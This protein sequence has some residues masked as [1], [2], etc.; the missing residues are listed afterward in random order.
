MTKDLFWNKDI[1]KIPSIYHSI[2]TK[3]LLIMEYVEGINIDENEKLLKNGYD[4]LNISNL[5]IKI[6][7]YMIFEN[8]HVHCDAHPGNILV[9]K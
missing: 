3:W 1:V 4:L 9:R 8:G 5:L 7:S 2:S 6:F